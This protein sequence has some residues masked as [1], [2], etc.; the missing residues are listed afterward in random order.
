MIQLA[1]IQDCFTSAE[2]HTRT[3]GNF[4]RAT[5]DALANTYGYLTPDLWKKESLGKTLYAENAEFLSQAK[6]K[7][8]LKQ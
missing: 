2:G 5:Y 7:K 3:K 1:G 4:V 8:S 6:V